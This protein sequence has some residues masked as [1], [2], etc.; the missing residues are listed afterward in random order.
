MIKKFTSSLLAGAGV[1]AL[2]LGLSSAPAQAA[3]TDCPSGMF[4]I[5]VDGNYSGARFQVSESTLID[6]HANAN[7]VY[8]GWIDDIGSAVY[9]RTPH[10]IYVFDGANCGSIGWRRLIPAGQKLTAPGSAIN[11]R[12]S[13]IQMWNAYPLSCNL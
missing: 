8:A 13:A 7:A 12:I 5:W 9:N 11:D 1:I 2:V 10:D 3:A 6:Q 4:C